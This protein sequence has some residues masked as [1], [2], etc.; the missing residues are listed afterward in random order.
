MRVAGGGNVLV[1]VPLHEEMAYIDSRIGELGFENL[2]PGGYRRGDNPCAYWR[3][4]PDGTN[5][6]LRF[7]ILDAEERDVMGNISAAAQVSLFLALYKPKIAF[8]VGLAGSLRPAEAG[9]GDV[10]ISDS[11]KFMFP[12]K[13]KT[14]SPENETVVDG[15]SLSDDA[16]SAARK[17]LVDDRKIFLNHSFF[18]LR[19]DAVHSPRARDLLRRYRDHLATSS[20]ADL[21]EPGMAPLGPWSIRFGSILG[22][23]WVVDSEAFVKFVLDRDANSR[24]DWYVQT[25]RLVPR[26]AEEATKRNKWS[27]DRLLA[28]DMES[29]GFLKAADAYA[30]AQGGDV[31]SAFVVRGI[32]DLAMGKSGLDDQS[33]G[34]HRERAVRNAAQVTLDLIAR[35]AEWGLGRG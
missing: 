33:G 25:A 5:F 27:D 29:Y 32:S 4:A 24:F 3:K 1:F 17:V 22:S 6:I 18:R 26:K 20:P 8:L 7:R 9:L 30:K 23:D 31:L 10:V 2:S 35:L 28:V 14:L 13:L 19:R 15:A 34:A 11:A 12:D 21:P 16:V